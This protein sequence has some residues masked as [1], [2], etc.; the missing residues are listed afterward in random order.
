MRN[1]INIYQNISSNR[2]CNKIRDLDLAVAGQHN[3]TTLTS[4][5][6]KIVRLPFIAQYFFKQL[7]KNNI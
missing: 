6:G 1:I 4:G 7:P 2:Q 5:M 3:F